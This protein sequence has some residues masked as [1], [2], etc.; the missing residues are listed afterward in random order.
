[1]T[2]TM[3]S[4]TE[5][6]NGFEQTFDST[7]SPLNQ[8]TEETT[9]R[10]KTNYLRRAFYSVFQNGKI[11]NVFFYGIVSWMMPPLKRESRHIKY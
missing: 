8:V 3:N 1:M 6:M 10:G 11:F 5:T 9:S 7:Q 2:M 4:G